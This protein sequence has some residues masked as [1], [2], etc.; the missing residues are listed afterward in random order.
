MSNENETNNDWKDREMGALWKKQGRNQTYLSGTVK[1]EDGSTRRVIVFE[2]KN[3][4]AE[5]QPDFV[6]YE[7]KPQEQGATAPAAA[8]AGVASSGGGDDLL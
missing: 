2:N 5:N 4:K 1:A 7:S 8:T 6:I 3:K